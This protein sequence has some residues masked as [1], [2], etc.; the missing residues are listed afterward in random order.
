MAIYHV[1]KSRDY[2]TMANYHLRDKR[3]SLA[4]KGLLSVLLADEGDCDYTIGELAERGPEGKDAVRSALAKLE[5]AGYIRRR[6]GH[7]GQGRFAG[8]EF[9]I[10]ETPLTENPTT[11]KPLTGEPLTENPTTVEAGPD[12]KINEINASIGDRPLSERE[13]KEEIQN[14]PTKPPRRNRRTQAAPVWKPERFAAFWEFYPR[15]ESKQAAIRAWDKLRPSDELIAVMGRALQRQMR[16]P[17]W[18]RGVGIPYAATWLNQR[19]WEDELLDKPDRADSQ[20]TE[21]QPGVVVWTPEM[22]L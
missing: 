14:P 5:A 16:K 8:N 22:E 3:L 6:Q 10:Y 21:E 9:L 7:D 20:A 13:N 11:A 12:I 15:G 17:E 18:Q 4:A 1:V 19:R 2:V